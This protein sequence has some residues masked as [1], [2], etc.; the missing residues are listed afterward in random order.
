MEDLKMYEMYEDVSRKE[1][2]R[3]LEDIKEHINEWD[4]DEDYHRSGLAHREDRIEWSRRRIERAIQAVEYS[5]M[6]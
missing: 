3:V 4:W 2:I 1:I 6:F 5:D